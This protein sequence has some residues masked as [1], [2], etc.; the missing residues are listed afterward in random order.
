MPTTVVNILHG[1]HYDT[2]IGRRG[3]GQSGYFGNPYRLEDDS[4]RARTSSIAK[5]RNYFYNRLK[6]DIEFKEAIHRLRGLK[7]G[8]FCK[9]K[10]CHG[11]VIAEYLDRKSV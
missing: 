3:K 8:C 7:L 4:D 11:D 5:F 6:T 2:Y 10:A 9:P 1:N